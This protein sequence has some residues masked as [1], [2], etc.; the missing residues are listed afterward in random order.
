[1]ANL[2]IEQMEA[3][4]NIHTQ[5]KSRKSMTEDELQKHIRMVYKRNNRRAYLRKKLMKQNT[6]KQEVEQE[7]TEE[8]EETKEEE[9]EEEEEETETETET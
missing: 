3:K 7:K 9:E 1:M 2:S 5:Y 8:E 4:L 6:A